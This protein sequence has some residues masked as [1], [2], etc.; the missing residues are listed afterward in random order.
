MPAHKQLLWQQQNTAVT[1]CARLQRAF[2]DPRVLH[3]LPKMLQ[4]L[5]VWDVEEGKGDELETFE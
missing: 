3:T 4:G 5:S 1:K 2:P